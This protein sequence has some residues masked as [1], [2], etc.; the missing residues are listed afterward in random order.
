MLPKDRPLHT[1]LSTSFTNFAQLMAEMEE[2]QLT[3][4]VELTFPDV[5]AVVLL[6]A[7]RV[8]GTAEET[9]PGSPRVSI[10]E[11]ARA[12]GG[13]IGVYALSEPLVA[14][15]ASLGT[16]ES[17]YR[18]LSTDF[19]SPDR[20]LRKLQDDGH[21][22]VVEV[23]LRGGGFGAIFM[24]AGE[25]VETVFERA[26]EFQSGATLAPSLLAAAGEGGATFNVSRAAAPPPVQQPVEPPPADTPPAVAPAAGPAETVAVLSLWSEILSRA[27]A[28]VD[29]LSSAGRFSS[30][31]KEACI[32]RA[33]EYP[34]LDPFAAEFVYTSGIAVYEGELPPDFS[35]ALGECLQDAL[36]RLAFQLKRADLESRVRAEMAGLASRHGHALSRFTPAGMA[37][38]S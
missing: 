24:R 22:G 32:D 17:L 28:L 26:G 36:A 2:R 5:S 20:L 35:E 25:V 15:L 7:G 11:R 14:L 21:T 10:G 18:D 16:R 9:P 33:V 30:A 4:Y 29:R 31:L 3:G 19:A 6:A 12:R 1:N 34:Y 8:A 37:L 23:A 38:V 27:E 13:T